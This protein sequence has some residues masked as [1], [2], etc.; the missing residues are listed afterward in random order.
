MHPRSFS[1]LNSSIFILNPA[2]FARLH[3]IMQHHKLAGT[4]LFRWV[5]QEDEINHMIVNYIN[6]DRKS[7]T[8]DAPN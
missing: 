8:D 7:H 4:L 6:S 5:L 1:I 3:N 2:S